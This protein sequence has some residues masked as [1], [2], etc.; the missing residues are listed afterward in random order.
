VLG[1]LGVLGVLGA[2]TVGYTALKLT[3]PIDDTEP[4]VPEDRLAED[5]WVQSNTQESGSKQNAGPVTVKS[6][7]NLVT[8]EDEQLV[9]R[10]RDRPVKIESDSETP[11]TKPISAYNQD[12]FSDRI[13]VFSASRT[14]LSP[15]VD[16]APGNVG[17]KELYGVITDRARTRFEQRLED[18]GLSDVEQHGESKL[19]IET[20]ETATLFE[21]EATYTFDG[22]TVQYEDEDVTFSGDEL[23]VAGHLAIWHHGEYFL[24]AGGAHPAE[25]YAQTKTRMVQRES[26]GGSY[27]EEVTISVDLALEPDEYEAD[28][29]EL[30]SLVE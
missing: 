4:A 17:M 29:K 18:A 20:G 10:L 26:N 19:E 5:G 16:N 9:Q 11:E 6:V 3:D 23:D 13:R 8:Y 1:G 30:I 21:Y 7:T 2:G 12:A 28:T 24:V 14:D 15:N 25:N 22:F 27:E